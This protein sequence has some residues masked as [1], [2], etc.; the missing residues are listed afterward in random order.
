MYTE[1]KRLEFLDSLRGLAALFVLLS[2]TFGAFV[3]PDSY[4]KM[5]TL[6]FVS[7]VFNGPEAVVMFFLLSGF[8]LSRPYFPMDAQNSSTRK[9]F[10]PTF[11]LRRL[12]RIWPPWFFVFILS[13]VAKKYF[14]RE[15]PTLPPIS[16]WLER[17]WHTPLTLADYLKQCAFL[18]H[19]GRKLLL[20]QD[21]SL[22]IELKGSL[23][24]PLYIFLVG[25]TKRF[26]WLV[27]LA[28]GLVVLIPNSH[29]Y[30]VF[31]TGVL[32]ARFEAALLG[33]FSKLSRAARL[34]V[35]ISGLI[36]YQSFG[37][38]PEYT[39]EGHR[40]AQVCWLLTGFGCALIVI[41]VVG[42]P[43]LREL[44]SHWS[45]VHLGRISYSLYLL[46]FIIIACLLPELV[47]ALNRWH[48]FER[49][50]LCPLTILASVITTG[51]GALLMYRFVEVPV[52][53]FGH[54]VT[55]KIQ[56]RFE[57]PSPKSTTGG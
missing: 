29:Y 3:W 39:G 38:Y 15:P 52:I 20:N 12:I 51:I 30:L 32:V 49:A 57:A 11:Y 19:D 1:P 37:L 41:S 50:L 46:Q 47:A 26:R 40:I 36:L 42:S 53:N 4:I 44:L 34:A 22:G 16:S 6:P 54:A 31:M 55:K 24:V 10:L 13:I 18:L 33:I 56:A 21:W 8:V 23:L 25:G 43:S 48:V 35:F 2:H 45:V 14:F 28:A 7:I 27:L 5:A 9:L 17:Y